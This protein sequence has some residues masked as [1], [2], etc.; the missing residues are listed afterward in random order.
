MAGQ[1]GKFGVVQVNEINSE[2]VS[3]IAV[4]K[5]LRYDTD[6]VF[7]DGRDI[8]DKNYVD[9]IVNTGSLILLIPA[10]SNPTT[11]VNSV[12]FDSP[13]IR[14]IVQQ[15]QPWTYPA[16]DDT[17]ETTEGASLRVDYQFVDNTKTALDS[18]DV[19]VADDTI[20][21]WIRII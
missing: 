17:K 5:V 10:G 1:D 12:D 15:F 8:P 4:G 18:I 7:S 13:S 2:E 6:N 3:E 19:W 9:N 21:T 16:P 14:P 11:L 20:D